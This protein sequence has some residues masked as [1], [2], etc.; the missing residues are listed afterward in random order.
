VSALG[1]APPSLA[2]RLRGRRVIV[3][4]GCGGVGKTTV[5]AALAAAAA[6]AGRRTLVLT[7]DPARR[8]ADALGVASLDDR[9]REL[10]GA[11]AERLGIGAGPGRLYAMMLDMKS[12]FDGLVARFAPDEATRRRILDNRIYQHLSDALAGSAEYAAMEKVYETTERGEF[13]LVVLDT[14]PAQ[15]ALDFLDAP[16]RLLEFLDSRLVQLLLHPAFAAGRFGFRV[17]QWGASRALRLI[18]R[19]TGVAFLEDVSEFLLAFEGM[20]EGFRERARRVNA[21]LLGPESGFV[22][23]SGA[24]RESVAHSL[25]FLERLERSEVPLDGVIVNRVHAWPG[26]AEPPATL[27]DPAACEAAAARLAQAL[28]SAEPSAADTADAA[29]AALEAARGYASL[30]RRDRRALRELRERISRARRFWCEVPE[31]ARDVHDLEG[32]LEIGRRLGVGGGGE[33][34]ED[35][36]A[37]KRAVHHP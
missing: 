33:A 29:R 32:L 23:V 17:F 18:E 12:T 35:D 15:H 3:C 28:R 4:V 36:F 7:I 20:S 24:A 8:L 10:D 25:E 13:D 11:A 27:D 14:P 9:P 30:V 21:L 16:R 1:A 26:G 5:A 2:T 34:G 31:F 6:R 19:M 22:L 37:A